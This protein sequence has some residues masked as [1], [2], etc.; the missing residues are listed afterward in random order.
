V[1]LGHSQWAR[2][3]LPYRPSSLKTHLQTIDPR[4]V[5][6]PDPRQ[7]WLLHKM[8]RSANLPCT[9]DPKIRCPGGKEKKAAEQLRSAFRNAA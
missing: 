4:L 9:S 1:A 2:G 6:D 8:G 3:F 5:G 7:L